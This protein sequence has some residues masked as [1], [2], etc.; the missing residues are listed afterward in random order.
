MI[1]LEF[2]FG[3]IR[4]DFQRRD[5]P[6]C[7]FLL[8]QSRIGCLP[9]EDICRASRAFSCTRLCVGYLTRMIRKVEMKPSLL[10]I[11]T[12]ILDKLSL[13]QKRQGGLICGRQVPIRSSVKASKNS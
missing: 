3:G 5:Y 13:L 10:K 9:L 11:G 12:G 7:R 8:A 2:I 1:P 4:G 6:P